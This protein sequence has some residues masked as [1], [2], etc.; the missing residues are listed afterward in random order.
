MD[1]IA[2]NNKNYKTVDDLTKHKKRFAEND[3]YI[4]RMEKKEQRQKMKHNKFSD[5]TPEELKSI[6]ISLSPNQ[7]LN[8]P[9]I[10]T[11]NGERKLQDELSSTKRCNP[12]KEVCIC[13]DGQYLKSG[14]CTNCQ[15]GCKTCISGKYCTSCWPGI[16]FVGTT[17]KCPSGPLSADGRMC[18][19]SCEP[20][21][22]WDFNR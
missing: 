11:L 14:I 15:A 8:L 18:N 13:P 6:L 20:G 7:T 21:Q 5:M 22:F 2:K 3:R 9:D 17:C 1:Y 16:D 12:K 19:T 10:N 4:K